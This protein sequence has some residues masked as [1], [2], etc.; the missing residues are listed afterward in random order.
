MIIICLSSFPGLRFAML[1]AKTAMVSLI[2]NFKFSVCEKTENPVKFNA[3]EF[4]LKA[5]NGLWVH[6]EAL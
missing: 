2:K 4:L 5:K 3:R 6:V 1:S